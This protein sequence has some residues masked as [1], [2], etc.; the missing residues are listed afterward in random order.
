M[1]VLT[2]LAMPLKFKDLM[3]A[4]MLKLQTAKIVHMYCQ[5]SNMRRKTC[6]QFRMA[7]CRPPSQSFG[8]SG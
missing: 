3:L 4:Q 8:G 5:V 2:V 6:A 1:E 7:P